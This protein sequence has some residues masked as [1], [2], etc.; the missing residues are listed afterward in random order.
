MDD[1]QLLLGSTIDCFYKDKKLA[2]KY[3]KSSE[4]YNAQIKELMST[5]NRTMFETSTGLVAK[6]TTQNRESFIDDLL[7]AKIKELNI[8]GIIKTKEY[9]DMEAL[10]N[11]IYNGQLNASEL[12]G[13]REVKKVITLKVG[14]KKEN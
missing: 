12:S 14:K 5:M 13:C 4:A 6:L 11:A 3:K 2:D 1:E 7:L 10:E 8:P 9:V